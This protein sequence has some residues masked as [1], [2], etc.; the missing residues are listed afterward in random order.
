MPNDD[1]LIRPGLVDDIP[2]LMAI[3]NHYIENTNARFT[4]ELLTLESCR[5][6]FDGYGAGRYRLLVAHDGAHLLGAAYSSRYR[7]SAAFDTTVETSIYLHP[8]RRRGGTG[9]RLY[10]ALI[11]LLQDEDVHLAV[12]GVAQ[13]N[14]ASNAL[15][16]KLGFEEVGTFKDYARKRGLWISSTWFQ[17]LMKED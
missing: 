1:V 15:H 17:R 8:D 2:E 9:T 14:E 6:W 16:R 12:A 4:T 10:S 5:A 13:P 7:P 11:A 3:F